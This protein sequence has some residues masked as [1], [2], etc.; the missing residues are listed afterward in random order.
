MLKE[1][2]MFKYNRRKIA[3]ND[4]F[5]RPR[6]IFVKEKCLFQILGNNGVMAVHFHV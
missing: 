4:N 5:N 3:G 2:I 6:T 1:K